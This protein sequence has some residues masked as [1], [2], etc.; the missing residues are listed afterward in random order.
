VL[1]PE[2]SG[3]RAATLSFLGADCDGLTS[4]VLAKL[5]FA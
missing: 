3:V 4:R 2:V 1:E 5:G